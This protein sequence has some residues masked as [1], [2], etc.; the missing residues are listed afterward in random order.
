MKSTLIAAI[1][2]ARL[3]REESPVAN[4]PSDAAGAHRIKS[5]IAMAMILLGIYITMH[6]A[7]GGVIHVLTEP[8][9]SAPAGDSS[10][11]H[12]SAARASNT[13]VGGAAR[14]S[15]TTSAGLRRAHCIDCCCPLNLEQAQT[16]ETLNSRVQESVRDWLAAPF[17]L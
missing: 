8:D 9:A 14:L 6:L 11:A 12:V 2:T 4:G 15:V 1:P 7:V 17:T 16:K 10:M 3:P 5:P 13:T